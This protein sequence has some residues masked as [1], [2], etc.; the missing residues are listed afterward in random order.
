MNFFNEISN[1]DFRSIFLL[2]K[3]SKVSQTQL[4][5]ILD[6]NQSSISKW[7]S[8]VANPTVENLIKIADYFNVSLDHLF[9]RASNKINASDL[10]QECI[11]LK[12]EN[13]LLKQRIEDLTG[14]DSPLVP[15]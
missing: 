9:G 12:D 8:G 3:K 10:Q 1:S 15:R 5:E 4:A 6:I 13:N 14:R 7:K 2:M 11:T